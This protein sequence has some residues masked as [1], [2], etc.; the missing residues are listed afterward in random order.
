MDCL[1]LH[2]VINDCCPFE[3]LPLWGA[4]V[5][6]VPALF[7]AAEPED[8]DVWTVLLAAALSFSRFA[9]T[10]SRARLASSAALAAA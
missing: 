1:K 9:F 5:P 7:D 3:T 6:P 10:A 4:V 2:S 8:D